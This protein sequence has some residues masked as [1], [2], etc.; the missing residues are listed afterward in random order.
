MN[1]NYRSDIDGLRAVAILSVLIYHAF[2]HLLPG[3]FI[4][5]DIFFVISGYLIS[6]AI[7]VGIDLNAFSFRDFYARRTRRIF[8]ALIIV[9]VAIYA[10]GFFVLLPYELTRLGK[11]IASS[12]SFTLNFVLTG[13]TGYFDAAAEQN[14]LLHLW[15]LCI[16]EQFYLLFPVVFL[17]AERLKLNR[18]KVVVA[19]IAASFLLNIWMVSE[20][21]TATFYLPATRFWEMAIGSFLAVVVLNKNWLHSLATWM[22]HCAALGL[23]MIFFGVFLIDKSML[24]P[25]WVA[26]IPSVGTGFVLL[27][28]QKNFFNMPLSWSWMVWVGKISFPMYLWHY[29]IFSYMRIYESSEPSTDTKLIAI[30]FIVGLSWLTYRFIEY[31]IRFGMIRQKISGKVVVTVLISLLAGMAIV[32]KVT[33]SAR[34]FPERIGENHAQMTK[35]KPDGSPCQSFQFKTKDLTCLIADPHQPPSH[36]LIGDSHATHFYAGISHYLKQNHRN[37]MLLSGPGCVPFLGVRTGQVKGDPQTCG[38]IV[39]NIHAYLDTSSDIKTVIL[40]TRGPITL[41]GQPFGT[42]SIF[43]RYIDSDRYPQA[44]NRSE[45]FASSLEAT[46][47]HLI[48]HKKNVVIML[49][50]PELGFNPLLCDK[51]P[52]LRRTKESCKIERAEVDL[53]NR[54]YRHLVLQ[55]ASRYPQVKVV[56]TFKAFCDERYCYANQGAE[57]IYRDDNHLTNF[58]SKMLIPQYDF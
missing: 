20:N 58:G 3:G 43:G 5:V 26:L 36:A 19:I 57:R 12:A 15:S 33:Q 29:P 10:L 21:A 13:N 9:L 2:P 14:P 6:H 55:V 23:T 40:A 8:P 44:K 50:N 22:P 32:G 42:E 11:N 47:A 17:M 41:T 25:G 1:M 4:G 56:D 46:L 37:L 49:D 52:L 28:S 18:L 51:L 39:D 31:P 35:E 48:A 38:T 34:G 53:R 27:A 7:F 54:D 30:I 45:L 16:E 24:F